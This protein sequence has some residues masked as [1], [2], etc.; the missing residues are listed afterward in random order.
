M[1]TVP[2]ENMTHLTIT[3]HNHLF[4][5]EHDICGSLQTT[6]QEKEK[7]KNILFR[8]KISNS[9]SFWCDVAMVIA[10]MKMKNQQW[11]IYRFR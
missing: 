3:A 1:E 10:A 11:P 9:E 8:W 5:T 7:Q 6:F 4:A 2:G